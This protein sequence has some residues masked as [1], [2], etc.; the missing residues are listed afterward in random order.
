MDV[1]ERDECKFMKLVLFNR[2]GVI[3]LVNTWTV[4]SGLNLQAGHY[5]RSAKSKLLGLF[6][7]NTSQNFC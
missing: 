4:N 6:A 1:D 3:V 5:I 2:G 7:S